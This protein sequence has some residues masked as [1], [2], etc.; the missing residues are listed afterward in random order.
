MLAVLERQGAEVVMT[1]VYKG[2]SMGVVMAALLAAGGAVSAPTLTHWST[3]LRAGPGSHYAV[4]DEVRH[5]SPVT[6]RGCADHWCQVSVGQTSGYIDQDALL[7]PSLP[8]A[9]ARSETQGCFVADQTGWRKPTP[10][11]FCGVASPTGGR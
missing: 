8:P 5:H 11:R 4:I 2:V 6:V 3:Y 10:T 9:A 1:G 7:L